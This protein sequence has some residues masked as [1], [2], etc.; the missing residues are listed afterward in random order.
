T[1]LI[2]ATLKSLDD[3]AHTAQLY[4][5]HAFLV[6]V[7][8]DGEE[9]VS[10][11]RPG[12]L[13]QRLAALPDNWT[14]ACFVP[15]QTS[16]FEAKRFGFPADNIAIWDTT[17]SGLTEVG[18]TI[19]RTTDTYMTSRA[20]GIRGSKTLFSTGADAVNAQ[21]VQQ[22][23]LT[24]LPSSKFVVLPV[25]ADGPIR[26]TVE[27]TGLTY[28]VGA[29]Y[30][31]L[32]KTE[33]IQANKAIAVRDKLSGAV[34]TGRNARDLLGLPATDVRVKPDSNP[35]FDVFVQSTSVNRKLIKGTTLLLL[36]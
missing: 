10:R 30:Y 22:A 6:Y 7:L 19:R 15:S 20:S 5:D 18:E 4:G 33:T 25:L 11:N 35:Q 32:M 28:T 23:G 13:A 26:E 14:V 12:A 16:K 3:L 27:A 34:Y 17:D 9:N 2:D 29:G 31:Q 1:A 21:T 8:T 36:V 24:K